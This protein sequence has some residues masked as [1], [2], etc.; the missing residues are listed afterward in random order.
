LQIVQ[1]QFNAESKQLRGGNTAEL[2][3]FITDA[4]NLINLAQQAYGNA[5]AS[6]AIRAEF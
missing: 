1:A 3:N 6:A 2:G 4:R 5:P